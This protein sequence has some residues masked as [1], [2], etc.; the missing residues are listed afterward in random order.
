[1]D[2]VFRD[3]ALAAANAH[4]VRFVLDIFRGI[5]GN[6]VA[7]PYHECLLTDLGAPEAK[8]WLGT[9]RECR[10]PWF[11][12]TRGCNEKEQRA[13]CQ[14][15]VKNPPMISLWA[16]LIYL[17]EGY[18][19]YIMVGL[20]ILMCFGGIIGFVHRSMPIT[21]VAFF[22]L[23][24]LGLQGAVSASEGR[25]TMIA[26]PFVAVLVSYGIRTIREFFRKKHEVR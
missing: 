2:D 26:Y 24:L 15:I 4:P 6:F 13:M 16:T 10:I 5:Y 12:Q 14:P 19:P 21:A 23:L 1:M 9:K 3:F 22:C 17:Y 7:P 8:C 25:Y 11:C 20:F 18:Y